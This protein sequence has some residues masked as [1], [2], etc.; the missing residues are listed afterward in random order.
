[1]N[2]S[3]YIRISIAFLFVILLLAA[4]P[5]HAQK[6]KVQKATPAWAEQGTGSEAEAE[7][8]GVLIDGEGL[9]DVE[10]ARFLV[11]GS[12]DDVGGIDVDRVHVLSDKQVVAYIRVS[13]NAVIDYF[14]IEL[15]TTRGR[16]G[17]GNTLFQV[18]EKDG[19]PFSGESISLDCQ[20]KTAAGDTVRSDGLLGLDGEGTYMDGEEKV[21][22][23]TGGTTQ[24]NLSGINLSSLAKGKRIHRKIDLAFSG[25][26]G[27]NDETAPPSEWPSH[28]LPSNIF[29]KAGSWSE[30][31]NV[32]LSVR[33]YRDARLADIGRGLPDRPAQDHIQLLGHDVEY[34]M[35]LRMRITSTAEERYWISLADTWVADDAKWQGLRC[36]VN[37]GTDP[38]GWS[39]AE[40]ANV[41]EDV[42]V[43]LWPDADGDF[44]ADGFTVTT[45]EIIGDP[46]QN[47]YSLANP[48][49]TS[50]LPRTA[51]ICSPDGPLDCSGADNSESCNFLGFVDVQF[52]WH[53]ESR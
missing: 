21:G 8:L 43:Y 15:T 7:A 52:T 19:T 9:I 1:M 6:I 22:C 14:D 34:A 46:P 2:S 12:R 10:S 45:G 27:P 44:V 53:A 20:L 30:M 17:K 24:P 18:V 33:P 42:T 36:W 29:E 25:Y 31:E 5:A 4:A 3:N 48:P 13:D 35:A 37:E 38:N 39:S 28:W 50:N 40:I 51:A 23:S 26:R 16:R 49:Q 47:G 11:S 32:H 41:A